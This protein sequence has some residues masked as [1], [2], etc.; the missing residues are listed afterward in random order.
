MPSK[1]E[2]PVSSTES[3]KTKS[4]IDD[5]RILT[6]GTSRLAPA[7]RL[8]DRARE[9]ELAHESIQSH[10][11]GKLELILK[12]IRNLQEEAK[13]IVDQAA[14]DA[15][16]HQVKCNFEK[17]VNQPIHLY[18]KADQMKYFSFVSPEEWGGNP[19]HSYLGSYI[20]RGDR[21]FERIDLEA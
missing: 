11:S 8:V 17:Q 19:P 21:S 1:E 4:A 9:I 20:M 18:V 10:T 14:T 13:R 16:L 7:I 5:R 6:Y 15:E 2:Q 12:Q 3:I